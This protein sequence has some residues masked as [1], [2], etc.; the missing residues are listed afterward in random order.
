[1]AAKSWLCRDDMDRQRLLDMDGRVGPVRRV[2][3]GV[4]ALALVACGPWLGC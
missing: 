2:S 1:M 4:I 3:L